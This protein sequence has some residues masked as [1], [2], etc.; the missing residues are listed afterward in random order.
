MKRLVLAAMP[1]A[2]AMPG[3]RAEAALP[4]IYDRL[5]QFQAALD[6]GAAQALESHG[7]IDKVERMNDGTFR[8]WSGRCFVTVRL[9]AIPPPTGMVGGTDYE[10]ELGDVAC[11]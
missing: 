4:P 3:G 7:L 6:A 5:L 11:D 9:K 8:I 2:L 1:L 10:S